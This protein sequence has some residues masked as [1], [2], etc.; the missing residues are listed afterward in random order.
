MVVVII[1]VYII[2]IDSQSIFINIDPERP[3]SVAHALRRLR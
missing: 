1:R 3:H 2:V